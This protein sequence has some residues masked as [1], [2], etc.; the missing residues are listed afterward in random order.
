MPQNRTGQLSQKPS[1]GSTSSD[2]EE[3]SMAQQASLPL[4]STSHPLLT[5]KRDEQQTLQGAGY[6]PT[7]C[8]LSNEE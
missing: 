8:L 3:Q 6:R 4:H 5:H 1:L 7:I 2:N